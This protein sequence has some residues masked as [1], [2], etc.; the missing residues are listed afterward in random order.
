M[1]N[2]YRDGS[3]RVGAHADRLTSLGPDAVIAGVSLGRARVFRLKTRW[4]RNP[5]GSDDC[6]VDVPLPHNSVCVM[7]PGC[8]ELWTHEILRD[9][10]AGGGAGAGERASRVSLTFRKKEDAWDASAPSCL[11]GRRCVLKTRRADAGFLRS[12]ARLG[13]SPG[14]GKSPTPGGHARAYYYTCD[15]RERR[16]AV[17]VFKPVGTRLVC[18]TPQLS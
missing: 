9:G 14:T 7:L 11:C 3:D 4:P 10:A 16:E 2:L 12:H 1:A 13:T 17:R 5:D 18:Q 15:S 6:A 8:Q